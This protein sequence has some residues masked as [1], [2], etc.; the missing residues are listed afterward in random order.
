MPKE[1]LIEKIREINRTVSVQWL[2]EFSA[3]KLAE[4]LDHL[5][6]LRQPRVRGRA[7]RHRAAVPAIL[8][9]VPE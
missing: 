9:H 3:P 7:W 1:L 5:E 6:L 4:Y 8:V 2:R